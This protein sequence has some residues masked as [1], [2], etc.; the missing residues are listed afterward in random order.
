MRDRH[1][2][3]L[4]LA[5][6]CLIK[7]LRGRLEKFLDCFDVTRRE[8]LAAI[9]AAIERTSHLIR[10]FLGKGESQ[11][12]TIIRTIVQEEVQVAFERIAI[13]FDKERAI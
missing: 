3:S 5:K 4:E 9:F 8:R 7:P 13:F 6:A 11:N 2:S 12:H 10:Q 1:G